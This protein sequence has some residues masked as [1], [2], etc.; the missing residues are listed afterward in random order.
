MKIVKIIKYYFIKFINIITFKP[1]Y[2]LSQKQLFKKLKKYDIVLA[3]MP[4]NYLKLLDIPLDH[5]IRPFVIYKKSFSKLYV[6]YV[7]SKDHGK[8]IK[9]N[10]KHYHLD[11]DSYLYLNRTYVL[12]KQHLIK[13]IDHLKKEDIRKL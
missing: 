11:K 7:S 2:S 6:Y 4:L 12:K 13:Y 8:N 5:R 3:N 10:K 9:L 1:T